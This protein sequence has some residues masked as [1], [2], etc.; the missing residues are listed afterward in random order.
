MSKFIYLNVSPDGERKNDCVTRAITFASGL[1]YESV[2]RK[3]FHT[4]K[5]LGCEKLC[6]S[7]YD[8]LLSD[9]LKYRKVNCDGER[10]GEFADLHPHG[11][12]L[13]RIDG[14]LSVVQDGNS[15]DT[16]DCRDRYCHIAWEVR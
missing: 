12:Y 8:F 10:I 16:F 11:T 15:I 14:H 9:V 13:I 2:R 3:L 6:W 4:A 1:P 7:C 5:L